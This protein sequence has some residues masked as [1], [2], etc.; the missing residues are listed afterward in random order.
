MIKSDYVNQMETLKV[1]LKQSSEAQ[2][3]L[4]ISNDALVAQIDQKDSQIQEMEHKYT[5]EIKDAQNE[6][7]A[8]VH[9][10]KNV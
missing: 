6:I 1:R 5:S 9:N 4:D 3:V 8:L 2:N 7:T 10:L